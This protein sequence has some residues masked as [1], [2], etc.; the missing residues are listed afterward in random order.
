MG[1][2]GAKIPRGIIITDISPVMRNAGK[3]AMRIKDRIT[4]ANI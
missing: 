2:N 4:A 3:I 1:N